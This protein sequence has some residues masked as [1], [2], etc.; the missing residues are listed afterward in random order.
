MY[1]NPSR[2]STTIFALLLQELCI[3]TG[4]GAR[5]HSS[6]GSAEEEV[7]SLKER[8]SAWLAGSVKDSPANVLGT[9]NI[10]TKFPFI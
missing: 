1:I 7:D 9:Y 4:S 3:S 10:C 8:L 6:E 2:F 5:L